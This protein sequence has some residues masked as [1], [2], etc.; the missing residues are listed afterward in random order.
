MLWCVCLFAAFWRH[1]CTN[2]L[3]L[4]LLT[5]F[6]CLVGCF[7]LVLFT[8]WLQ[9]LFI[10]IWYLHVFLMI[11]FLLCLTPLNKLLLTLLFFSHKLLLIG[12]CILLPLL[13]LTTIITT[14]I[15]M[16]L[17][18]IKLIQLHFRFTINKDFLWRY[19]YNFSNFWC[20]LFLLWWT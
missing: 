10:L 20:D 13:R 8:L 6:R 7:L 11:I 14:I 18:S 1:N 15:V 17:T 3:V 2:C 16:N 19:W 12:I 4:L 9:V 5:Y